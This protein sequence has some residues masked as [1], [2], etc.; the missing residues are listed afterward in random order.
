MAALFNEPLPSTNEERKQLEENIDNVYQ[1][2]FDGSL[3]ARAA[4]QQTLAKMKEA[5]G[6]DYKKLQ[7]K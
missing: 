3:K 7:N 5:M 1:I 6:L 2:L 4:A